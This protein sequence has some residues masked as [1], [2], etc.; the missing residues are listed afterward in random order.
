MHRAI[1]YDI[2]IIIR[3]KKRGYSAQYV[4]DSCLILKKQFPQFHDEIFISRLVP[5]P[6]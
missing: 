3:T 1:R 6:P 2:I 4:L 5:W